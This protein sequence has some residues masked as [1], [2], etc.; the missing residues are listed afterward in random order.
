M[1]AES[2]AVPGAVRRE[3]GVSS[4]ICE[5]VVQSPVKTFM[6]RLP[7]ILLSLLTPALCA[8]QSIANAPLLAADPSPLLVDQL[9]HEPAYV[10]PSLENL[11]ATPLWGTPDGRVLAIVGMANR[12][13]PSKPQSP[14]IGSA[15]D[16]K[17]VDV[18]NFVTTG[19]LLNLN[20]GTSAY[21]TIGGGAVIGPLYAPEAALPCGPQP[22]PLESN[23][24]STLLARTAAMQVGAGW[25]ILDNLDLDLSYGLSWLRRDNTFANPSLPTLDLFGALGN[26][27]FPT[28]LIPG[29]ESADVQ[30]SALSALGHWRLGAPGTLDFGASLSRLQLYA[31]N[32]PPLTSLNQAAVTFGLR[33]GTFSGVV[34]GHVLGPSDAFNSTRWAGLD[35]GFS[36]HTPWQGELIFGTQNLWSS[37]AVPNLADPGSRE[38]DSNQARVP[39]VQ[40]HQDL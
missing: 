12:S 13:I 3:L 6:P 29:L 26:A 14:Q 1:L 5:Y 18:T 9:L 31:P 28:L 20:H 17:L 2:C 37:G 32:T 30:N 8:G 21:A 38:I 27:Q 22:E 15:A 36:W 25:T 33:H 34:T 7:A 19:L 16:W 23:C 24:G 11:E 35:I 10:S 40:Y 39:Y 4:G